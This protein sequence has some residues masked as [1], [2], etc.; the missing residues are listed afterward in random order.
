MSMGEAT[1]ENSIEVP[2]KIKNWITMWFIKPTS[3]YQSKGVKITLSKRYQYSH[4]CRSIIHNNQDRE[5]A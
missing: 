4:I 3:E 1:V 2:Q 5:A